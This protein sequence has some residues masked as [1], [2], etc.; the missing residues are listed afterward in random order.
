L[1]VRSGEL[2]ES[3]ARCNAFQGDLRSYKLLFPPAKPAFRD[4]VR[5]VAS[6]ARRLPPSF[7][8]KSKDDAAPA[9][10]YNPPL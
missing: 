2:R 4:Y 9:V 8:P 7:L 3:L 5:H 10:S 6:A 1:P